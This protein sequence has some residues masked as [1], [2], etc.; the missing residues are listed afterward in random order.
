MGEGFAPFGLVAIGPGQ[1]EGRIETFKDG[2]RERNGEGEMGGGG[3][4]GG[5]N[6]DGWR[7]K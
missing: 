6:R 5:A 2:E 1:R 4:G 7:G 3:G